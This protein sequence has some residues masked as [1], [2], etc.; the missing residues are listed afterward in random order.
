M[1]RRI[2]AAVAL[3]LV[4]S[5]GWAAAAELKVYSTIGVQAALEELT[6]K[7]EQASGHKLVITW[8]TAAV[9]TRRLQAGETADVVVLTR[10]SLDTLAKEGKAAAEPTFASSGMG[11]V[12][13][14][15][16]A[17]PDISNADAFKRTLLD[18]AT[19][20]YSDPAHGGASGVYLSKL[21]ERMGIAEQVKAKTKH[22]PQGGNAAILVANGEAA[23]A[24]QQVPEVISVAGVDFVGELPADLNNVTTYAASAVPGTKQEDGAKALVKF[25]HSPEAAAVFKARGLTRR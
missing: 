23:L 7:F 25:L 21:L 17:R 15:G 20:A 24:I 8:N 3:S 4:G 10:A 5:A 9:L 6:P 13:K 14:K 22:P 19:I 12:V 16:A 18:A 1:K 2:L 11:L